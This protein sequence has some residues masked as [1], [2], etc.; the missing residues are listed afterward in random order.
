MN[1]STEEVELPFCESNLVIPGLKDMHFTITVSC[2]PAPL[3]EKRQAY[4]LSLQR[5][6]SFNLALASHHEARPTDTQKSIEEG[7]TITTRVGILNASSVLAHN[8][9]VNLLTLFTWNNKS[10]IHNEQCEYI[11]SV[12]CLKEFE[13]HGQRRRFSIPFFRWISRDHA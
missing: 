3:T 1:L 4:D 5:S 11:Q 9:S 8:M 7:I 2:S 13:D 10:Q 6:Y 12:D